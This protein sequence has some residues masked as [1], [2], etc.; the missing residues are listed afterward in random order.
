MRDKVNGGKYTRGP[1]HP[2][3]GVRDQHNRRKSSLDQFNSRQKAS[4]ENSTSGRAHE[5]RSIADVGMRDQI[6]RRKGTRINA[7]AARGHAR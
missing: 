6:N 4:R 5:I 7:V 2:G 1:Y 3:E